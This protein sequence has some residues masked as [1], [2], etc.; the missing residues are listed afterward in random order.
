MRNGPDLVEIHL[1]QFGYLESEPEPKSDPIAQ[2]LTEF[3]LAPS[4]SL[5]FRPHAL[6]AGDFAPV[7]AVF[8]EDLILGH[9]HGDVEVMCEHKFLR[10]LQPFHHD[11]KPER[12]FRTLKYPLRRRNWESRKQ[13]APNQKL[14]R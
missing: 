10:Y 7:R 9:F 12:R 3:A 1:S 2:G 5:V 14:K 11:F 6:K 8:F 13:K 4:E